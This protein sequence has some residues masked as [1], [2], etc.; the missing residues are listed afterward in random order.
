[1]PAVVLLLAAAALA[2]S[3]PTV[4]ASPV[5]ARARSLRVRHALCPYSVHRLDR[6]TLGL[7]SVRWL[8]LKCLRPNEVVEVG[9]DLQVKCRQV[10]YKAR[11]GDGRFFRVGAGCV[12]TLLPAGLPAKEVIPDVVT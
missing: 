5:E 3:T 12:A 2:W 10:S 4:G 7:K 1:M 11:L 9:V 8:E 6:K